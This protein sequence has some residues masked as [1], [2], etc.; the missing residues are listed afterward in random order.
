MSDGRTPD[1]R[2]SDIIRKAAAGERSATDNLSQDELN[3]L[4]DRVELLTADFGRWET[5]K[6]ASTE[7]IEAFKTEVDWHWRIRLAVAIACGLLVLFL[8]ILL[9]VGVHSANDFKPEQSHA[10]IALIVG[11]ITGSVVVT[12][13]LVKGAF[14]NLADRNA[15]LPMPEHVY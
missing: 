8:V 2:I 4:A 13:A 6:A 7:Y 9:M 14:S 10:L 3:A 1:D 11:C 12:I 5:Y 15:G